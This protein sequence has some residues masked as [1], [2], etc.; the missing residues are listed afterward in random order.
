MTESE[1]LLYGGIWT[2]CAVGAWFIATTKKAP[3]AGQ[4]AIWGF[5]L[6]PFGLFAAIAFA[7]P[8]ATTARSGRM[9]GRCGKPLSPAWKAKCNHCGAP[10]AEFPPVD[11]ASLTTPQP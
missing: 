3:D 6:G 11:V 8:A 4:W 7:K 2:V 9:C 1:L 5:L 10:F